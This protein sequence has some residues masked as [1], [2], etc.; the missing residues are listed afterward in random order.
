MHGAT[1]RAASSPGR[2]PDAGAPLL[3]AEAVAKRFSLRGRSLA[4]LRGVDLQVERGEFVAVMGAS[5]SGKST[6]LHLLGGLDQPTSGRVLVDGTDLARLSDHAL[7]LLRRR[8]IGFIFQFFNLLPTLTV[9]ENIVLPL[10]IAG[11]RPEAHA[12]ILQILIRLLHLSDILDQRP[13]ELSGGEQQRVAVARALLEGPDLILAD[14]PT[15]NLDHA[16]G[17]ELLDYL[18]SGC[19]HLGRTVVMVTHEAKAANYADRVLVLRD[20]AVMAEI[21]LGR[22]KRRQNARALV[23]RLAELGL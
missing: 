14:E 13:S 4:V 8:R 12:R 1:E 11:K 23:D 18:W 22:D 3:R 16:S 2:T 20:G 6:L 5:G 17:V 15:G 19:A 10:L 21:P 7:T 9:R